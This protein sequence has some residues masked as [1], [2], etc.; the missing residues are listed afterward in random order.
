MNSDSKL[1]ESKMNQGGVSLGAHQ[2]GG[3]LN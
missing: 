2:R 1:I 3:T